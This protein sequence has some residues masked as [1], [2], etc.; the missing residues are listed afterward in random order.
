MH[1]AILLTAVLAAPPSVSPR[2]ELVTIGWGPVLDQ[3]YGH[4]ALCV[5]YDREPKRSHCYN[6]GA[7]TADSVQALRN[8]AD[9]RSRK[10]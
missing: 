2:I 9:G 3:R 10:A 4:A 8:R 6:Y 7:T 5:V 1:A